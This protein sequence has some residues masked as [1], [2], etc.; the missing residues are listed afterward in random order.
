MN[1]FFI[2]L[3]IVFVSVLTASL[4]IGYKR[5]E[6]IIGRAAAWQNTKVGI[7]SSIFSILAIV[8]IFFL[9]FL[10]SGHDFAKTL[11]YLLIF[12]SFSFVFL[13]FIPFFVLIL[14]KKK[15]LGAELLDVGRNAQNRS[16]IAVAWF[17]LALGVPFC[18]FS[19]FLNLNS[20]LNVTGILIL[21]QSL[22]LVGSGFVSLAL[23]KSGLKF[24]ENG[25]YGMHAFIRWENFIN[26]KIEKTKQNTLRMK[27]KN[28]MPFVPGFLNFALP[29]EKREVVE[30]FLRAKLPGLEEREIVSQEIG[31]SNEPA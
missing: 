21:S 4:F 2:V 14:V 29:V 22:F 15:W 30:E 7:K 1:I 24:Y 10:F 12:T 8:S 17:Q 16:F 20:D 23:S 6:K 19:I 5:A 9:V 26:F 18:F 28:S 27:Y 3:L 11:P 13:F 25:V 31:A